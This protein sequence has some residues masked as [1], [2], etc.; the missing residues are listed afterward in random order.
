MKRRGE[1]EDDEDEGWGP[2]TPSVVLPASD[3]IFNR[4]LSFFQTT[5]PT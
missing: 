1:V 3:D 2:M 5:N 4:S